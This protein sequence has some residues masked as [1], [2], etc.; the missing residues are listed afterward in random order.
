MSFQILRQQIVV[1]AKWNTVQIDDSTFILL[2][3]SC[4]TLHLISEWTRN[5]NRCKSTKWSFRFNNQNVSNW[6]TNVLIIILV[7]N[8]V[9]LKIEHMLS[10]LLALLY[11]VFKIVW[12]KKTPPLVGLGLN[13]QFPITQKI[14]P[15]IHLAFFAKG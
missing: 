9:Y 6:S 3:S 8:F 4:L 13:Y 14:W 11:M 7:I 15:D 1:S 5:T 12:G 10:N 2:K